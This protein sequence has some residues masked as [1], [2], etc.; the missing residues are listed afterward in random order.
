MRSEYGI[1]PWEVRR[2]T[3]RE[4]GDLQSDMQNRQTEG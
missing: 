4:I 1:H 3:L 2:Y